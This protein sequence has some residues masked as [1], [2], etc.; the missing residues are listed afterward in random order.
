MGV[1]G[2]LVLI[3]INT[4]DMGNYNNLE[5]WKIFKD[6]AISIY[7][8]TS[9]KAFARDFSLRDQIRRSAISVPSNLAEG[10][11]SGV[12]KNEC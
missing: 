12:S 4:I 1:L 6:I 7:H 9:N 3:S 10:D 11:E 5:V 2:F 8:I